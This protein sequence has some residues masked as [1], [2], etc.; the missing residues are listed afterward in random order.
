[1][2]LRTRFVA[3]LLLLVV[4]F[5]AAVI[6]YQMK[7]HE[8]I[9]REAVTEQVLGR[10]NPRER[11]LC[12]ARPDSWPQIGR[13]GRRNRIR[14]FGR[15]FAY[16]TEFESRNQQAPSFPADLRRALEGQDSAVRGRS[17][18]FDVAVRM[19]WQE[20]PCSVLLLR[21][22]QPMGRRSGEPWFPGLLISLGA[23]I[24]ALFAANPIVKR[25]QKLTQLV[26][27][28]GDLDAIKGDDEV[29]ELAAAF[30]KKRKQLGERVEQV[31]GQGETLRNYVADTAHDVMIPVTVLQGHLSAF[32]RVTD[33]G[34]PLDPERLQ[35][36]IEECHYLTSIFR[37][38]S[39]SAKLEAQPELTTKES[40][41]LGALVE[42]V[43][44]RH[45]ALAEAS[46]VSLD[47]GV[48]EEPVEVSGDVTLLEQAV[49]NLVH[50]SIRY[51]HRGGHVALVLE[52]PGA[53]RFQ[54]EVTDDGPGMPS[55]ELEKITDRGFRSARARTRH[56]S[57]LG[58]GLSI[59]SDVAKKHQF[60]LRFESPVT[61]ELNE[62]EGSEVSAGEQGT[63][64]R[65]VLSGR[66]R[67]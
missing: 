33:Q 60:K 64:L 9:V 25:I 61:R 34:K 36:A 27:S 3:T 63:G 24:L 53:K 18:G 40:V 66:L 5:A 49:G 65:V 16:G 10:M 22:S 12:E 11:A 56:P 35:E 59:V 41:N 2:T 15:V 1:M 45:Q 44:S 37:N 54:L 20:G 8:Q 57:G 19:P 58:L 30:A 47:F 38:L 28:D 55:E 6:F 26:S 50:N 67:K 32:R 43:V 23:V 4:P 7:H 48:P 31:E 14:R 21:R 62:D 17:P 29:A 46:G 51:N 39:V 13:R 42:R 52:Q